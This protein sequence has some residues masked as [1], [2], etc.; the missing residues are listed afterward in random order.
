MNSEFFTDYST[1]LPGLSKFYCQLQA[2]AGVQ[3][4]ESGN[5]E[6]ALRFQTEIG[7]R[8]HRL[9]AMIKYQTSTVAAANGTG[10]RFNWYTARVSFRW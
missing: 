7:V 9:E 10:Y 3:R 5:W 6:P 8:L 1:P 4:I 2:A